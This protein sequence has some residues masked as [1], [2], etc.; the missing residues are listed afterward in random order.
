M[1]VKQYRMLTDSTI[2]PLATKGTVVQRCAMHDYGCAND[3]TRALGVQHISL[4]LDPDGGYPFF[5]H[6]LKDLEEIKE[7]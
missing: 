5:T 2:E 3:D 4:T 7:V 6:P 1:S